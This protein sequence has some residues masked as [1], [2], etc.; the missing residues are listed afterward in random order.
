M[1]DA[2]ETSAR[3]L[4]QYGIHK[5]VNH[6]SKPISGNRR[7]LQISNHHPKRVRLNKHGDRG[8]IQLTV[9]KP[10][11]LKLPNGVSE[12]NIQSAEQRRGGRLTLRA[13]MNR[14][15]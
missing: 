2:D 10:A 3:W 9:N 15:Q 6:L 4:S 14:R 8:R 11:V 7:L 5:P 13:T 12:H 1:H